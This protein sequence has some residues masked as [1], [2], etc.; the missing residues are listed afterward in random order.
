M[1]HD[2]GTKRGASGCPIILMEN[3]KIIWLYQEALSDI[4]NK[5]NIG[6]SI[7]LIINKMSFIKFTYEINDISNDIQII[8]NRDI[9]GKINLEIE[10]KMIILNKGKKAKLI[11]TKK[12]NKKQFFNI[13][14]NNDNF[15]NKYMWHIF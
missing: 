15:I 5:T 10:S 2:I 14:F 13:Y 1:I 7:N 9:F 4:K 12:F 8:N 6:I 11:F 3:S